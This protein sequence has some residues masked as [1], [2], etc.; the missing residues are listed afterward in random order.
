M[1]KAGLATQLEEGKFKEGQLEGFVSH[2]RLQRGVRVGEESK[3]VLLDFPSSR[4]RDSRGPYWENVVLQHHEGPR[5]RGRKDWS[6]K[7]SGSSPD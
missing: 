4:P 2:D 5:G 6:K 7:M 1:V 3:S